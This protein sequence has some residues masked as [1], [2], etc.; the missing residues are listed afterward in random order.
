MDGLLEPF[1]LHDEIQLIIFTRVQR[2]IL[3]GQFVQLLAHL[4][5]HEQHL[6]LRAMVQGLRGEVAAALYVLLPLEQGIQLRLKDLWGQKARPGERFSAHCMVRAWRAGAAPSA[7]GYRVLHLPPPVVL[8]KWYLIWPTEP[9]SN[10]G[11]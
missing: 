2:E 9:A 1:G 8:R 6:R 5:L 7:G 4:L 11:F 10:A 3:V